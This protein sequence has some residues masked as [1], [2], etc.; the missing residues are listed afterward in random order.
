MPCEDGVPPGF[1]RNRTGCRRSVFNCSFRTAKDEFGNDSALKSVL[2]RRGGCEPAL[3]IWCE[4][5]VDRRPAAGVCFRPSGRRII[6]WRQVCVS[7]P[8]GAG[9][10]PHGG[11]NYLFRK[12]L[13]VWYRLSDSRFGCAGRSATFGCLRLVGRL[14]I[15]TERSAAPL[16]G[17]HFHVLR[18]HMASDCSTG[19]Q[20]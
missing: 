14:A 16:S 9:C 3:R 7:R 5:R 17:T 10:N 15:F 18:M 8:L 19:F 11:N 13:F 4:A 12:L 1:F 20:P 2:F 6:L